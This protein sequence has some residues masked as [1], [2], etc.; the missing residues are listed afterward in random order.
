MEQ[1]GMNVNYWR[2]EPSSPFPSPFSDTRISF[3]LYAHCRQVRNAG[4]T[5]TLFYSRETQI[6][7]RLLGYVNL[8]RV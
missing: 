5:V 1:T 7:Y 4:T 2:F 6:K 8:S 3:L